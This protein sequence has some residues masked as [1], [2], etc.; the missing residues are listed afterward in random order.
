MKL[1]FVGTR[2][3]IDV[4]S[5]QH[6]KHSL[7]AISQGE[8]HHGISIWI[9]CGKDWQD[10]I[11]SIRPRPQA[12]FLT[13]SHEDHAEGLRYQTPTHVY[14]TEETWDIIEDYAI[15]EYNRHVIATQETIT[16]GN[17]LSI[18]PYNV[19]HSVHAP[20]VGYKITNGTCTIF[21][22]SDLAS[23][24]NPKEALDGVHLYI[25]DGSI[26]DR[27]ILVRE[28]SGQPTGHASIE[29]QLKWCSDNGIKQALLLNYLIVY[30]C[31]TLLLLSCDVLCID[32]TCLLR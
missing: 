22:A 16:K 6:K 3:N 30:G 15:P 11:E 21:Y 31:I 25:G 26:I 14:A 20:A 9:D 8:D 2:A 4:L 27:N 17:N 32:I 28:H 10:T 13:H 29:E 18:T 7:L 23:I 5:E 19:F 24:E 12:I 1:T